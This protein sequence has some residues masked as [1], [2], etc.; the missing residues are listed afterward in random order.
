MHIVLVAPE[1]PQNTGN[2]ARLCAATRSPL[3]LVRPLG[4][5]LH[6]RH[7]KRAGLD[8]WEHVDLRVHDSLEEF[9]TE[10]PANRCHFVSTKGRRIYTQCAFS[11]DDVLVFGSEGAGLPTTL[12]QQY[13]DRTI[14]IPM[15]GPV[16]SLNLATA[17]GIV[18]FEAIRQTSA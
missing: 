2:V 1:I 6:D 14:S 11:T 4:F 13:P 5:V 16:R 17:A 9:F 8:Y 7:L 12:L 18:L 15:S 3:H 10:L